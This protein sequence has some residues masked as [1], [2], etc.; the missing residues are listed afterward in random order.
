MRGLII[1]FDPILMTSRV[2]GHPGGLSAEGC[3]N[4]R[5]TADYH[6][7]RTGSGHTASKRSFDSKSSRSTYYRNCSE[8]RSAGAAPVRVGDPGNGPHLDTDGHVTCC[9]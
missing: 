1:L 9:E 8:A 5:R 3:H 7:R 6:C 4:N 2:E